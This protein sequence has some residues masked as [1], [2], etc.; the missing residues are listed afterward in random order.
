MKHTSNVVYKIAYPNSV[1]T[2]IL[3]GAL[4]VGIWDL[5][6]LDSSANLAVDSKYFVN[7]LSFELQVHIV[8]CEDL[9][10]IMIMHAYQFFFSTI[11]FSLPHVGKINSSMI[12]SKSCVK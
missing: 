4:T 8:Q 1:G 10:E 11:L 6:T 7:A 12:I 3:I 9:N 5:I 2:S